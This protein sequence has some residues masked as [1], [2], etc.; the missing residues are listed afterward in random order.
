MV[1]NKKQGCVVSGKYN[2]EHFVRGENDPNQEPQKFFADIVYMV[3]ERIANALDDDLAGVSGA[4]PRILI[5]MVI[6]NILVNLMFNSIIT[7]DVKRRLEMLQES[8]KEIGEMTIELW[9][10]LEAQRADR[11]TAH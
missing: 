1:T 3:K 7:I 9:T 11:S 8:L 10:T 2:T 6:T 5:S 4:H